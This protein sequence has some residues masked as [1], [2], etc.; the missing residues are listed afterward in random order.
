MIFFYFYRE[1]HKSVGIV[2]EMK[3]LLRTVMAAW[4]IYILL[5]PL[6]E[7]SYSHSSLNFNP[8]DL[9]TLSLWLVC[10]QIWIRQ[11]WDH[12]SALRD[13]WRTWVC[14]STLRVKSLPWCFDSPPLCRPSPDHRS[15]P[16]NDTETP[17]FPRARQS[18]LQLLCVF[19]C[20]C[21]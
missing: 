8:D 16:L 1:L 17:C 15:S 13:G 11:N 9:F 21:L 14:L 6:E 7:I 10:S 3:S 19:V 20:M 2:L 18:K 5:V 12:I 4:L